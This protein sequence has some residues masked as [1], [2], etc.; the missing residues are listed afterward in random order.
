MGEGGDS[1]L[2][3]SRGHRIIGE[4]TITWGIIEGILAQNTDAILEAAGHK[5]QFNQRLDA[6][7]QQMVVDSEDVEVAERA[8][9]HHHGHIVIQ[10]SMKAYSISR[11]TQRVITASNQV[12]RRLCVYLPLDSEITGGVE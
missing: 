10:H 3:E 8:V 2:S 9:L 11:H 6:H 4:N 12:S 7:Q 1:L 5:A